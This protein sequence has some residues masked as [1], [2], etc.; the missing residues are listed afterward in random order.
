MLALKCKTELLLGTINEEYL[1]WDALKKRLIQ[2][3]EL[4]C[5]KNSEAL[6]VVIIDAADNSMFAAN[7][8]KQKCFLCE[9]LELDLPKNI[10]IVATART[11]RMSS[12]PEIEKQRNWRFPY[13]IKKIV[14]TI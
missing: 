11:E 9:L 8:M 12:L 5:G 6:V 13:S 14:W 2:A 4:V 7:T 10:R 1:W 3:S